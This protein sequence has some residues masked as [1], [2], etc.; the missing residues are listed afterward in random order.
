MYVLFFHSISSCR[1]IANVNKLLPY[2]GK[3]MLKKKRNKGPARPDPITAVVN[4]R[5]ARCVDREEFAYLWIL[6]KYFVRAFGNE[7]RVLT[8][9]KLFFFS[10]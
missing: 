1:Y 6:I 3:L 9:I 8:L 2:S 7:F 5:C 10:F 4:R